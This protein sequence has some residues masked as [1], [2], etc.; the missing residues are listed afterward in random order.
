MHQ[1]GTMDDCCNMNGARRFSLMLLFLVYYFA[2]CLA[3]WAVHYHTVIKTEHSSCYEVYEDNEDHSRV[4]YHRWII[5]SEIR[6]FHQLLC[7]LWKLSPNGNEQ[8]ELPETFSE[9]SERRI[10]VDGWSS[11]DD[12]HHHN[13]CSNMSYHKLWFLRIFSN[14]VD[15]SEDRRA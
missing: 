6:A 12:Y 8:A 2:T 13:V 5:T 3:I 14:A 1:N 4:G 7:I 10:V 11:T 9:N 15:C